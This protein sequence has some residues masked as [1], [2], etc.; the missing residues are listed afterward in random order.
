[1]ELSFCVCDLSRTFT[2]HDDGYKSEFSS[3]T[4]LSLRV[5]TYENCAQ[6][7]F[8]DKGESLFAF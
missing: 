4:Y 3:P 8:L 2:G 7:F 1:M 5:V 6:A